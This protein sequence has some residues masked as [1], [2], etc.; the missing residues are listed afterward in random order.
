MQGNPFYIDPTVGRSKGQNEFA[1]LGQVIKESRDQKAAQLKQQQAR[2][3]YSQA[4]QSG[5]PKELSRFM[6]QYPELAESA[7]SSF[8]FTNE[9]TE[10]IVRDTYQ[11]VLA[12]PSNAEQYLADGIDQVGQAGGKPINMAQDLMMMRRD[13]ESA[14]KNIRMGYASMDPK[15]YAALSAGQGGTEATANIKDFARYQELKRTNPKA[16]EKFAELI[17]LNKSGAEYQV[18]SGEMAGWVF[19]KNAPKGS[20]WSLDP[21]VQ[22]HLSKKA[23]SKRLEGTALG[24]KD[25]RPIQKDVS[26]MIEPAID[27]TKAADSLANLKASS[28][29]T[30]QLAAIFK[31]MKALDPASVVR[32]GEQQMAKSTGGPADV[33][34][35]MVQNLQG[36]GSITETVFNDMVATARNLSESA[37]HSS[38]SELNSYLDAYG[39]TLGDD[40]KSNLIRRL[41]KSRLTPEKQAALKWIRDNPGDPRV[42][43]VRAKVF[44]VGK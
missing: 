26:T 14:L 10:P 8:G 18:G 5:D 30:A 44:G 9:Q 19:D 34:V 7:K 15:G 23:D 33:F 20:Q 1:G 39:E 32:E 3:A 40:F 35:G 2:D 31:L 13:P 24:A 6:S 16:A 43:S 4:V 42:E 28:S 22:A 17:G 12:D 37:I 38:S 29:A 36:K 11:R 27:I 41:P 25:I 21:K